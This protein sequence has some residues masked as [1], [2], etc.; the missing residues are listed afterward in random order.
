MRFEIQK[1]NEKLWSV[2]PLEGRLEGEVVAL[3]EGVTLRDVDLMPRWL[4]GTIQAV[5]GATLHE[6]AYD[7]LDVI[8]GL[9]INW[10]FKVHGSVNG[11]T[12]RYVIQD[13]ECWID[14]VSKRR[15]DYAGRAIVLGSSVRVSRQAT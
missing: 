7:D 13:K 9:R 14:G 12:V 2:K 11:G 15:V 5:W 8:A 4:E 6:T 1:L 3:V 10:P